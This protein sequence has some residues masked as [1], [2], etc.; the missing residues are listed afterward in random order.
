MDKKEI[1]IKE[2]KLVYHVKGKGKAVMLIHGFGEKSDV[3]NNQVEFLKD[4]FRII[5]PDIPGSGE[6]ELQDDMSMEGMAE[7]IKGILDAEKIS[8]CVIIGHSMGGYIL[9]AFAEKYFS[10]L[11]GFGLFHS[12][13]FADSE[14]K[15]A[16]RRKGIEFI[17]EHGGFT[18]LE[19]TT[20]NLFSPVTHNRQPELI[21]KQI[22][23]LNNF[24]VAALVSYY[25]GMINRPD[26]TAILRNS[27]SPVLFIAGKYDNAV[28][29]PDILKQCHLPSLSY[30]HILEN[31]GHMGM[32][33]E[34]DKANQIL[35]NFL[36]KTTFT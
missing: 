26:R 33:E 3:W 2:K 4:T 14:E 8:R 29:L 6:S 18:F 16:T 34:T 11:E 36:D 13:G 27:T 23:T 30:I 35:K 12:T 24:S 1:K 21:D 20:P 22:Q 19:N 15:K 17:N 10:Y 32:L 25:E 28:P 31:S 9:L 7:S 5:V